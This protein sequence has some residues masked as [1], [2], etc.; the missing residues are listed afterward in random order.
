[1]FAR[2][3]HNSHVAI[4]ATEHKSCP[5]HS[6]GLFSA[7]CDYP[8]GL[9][10]GRQVASSAE[11]LGRSRAHRRP[12]G[13]RPAHQGPYHGLQTVGQKTRDTPGNAQLL[14]RS[15]D[16]SRPR[17]WTAQLPRWKRTARKH[18]RKQEIESHPQNGTRQGCP[19]L[20]TS[21]MAWHCGFALLPAQTPAQREQVLPD[22]HVL[23]FTR[24]GPPRTG[25]PGHL[26]TGA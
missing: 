11:P 20:G 15:S 14:T 19:S 24:H 18:L 7:L 17:V 5:K 16:L 1:M 23:S 21:G 22:E 4:G 25:R 6:C 9:R 8:R 12:A 10:L 2:R 26:G 13:K 3:P